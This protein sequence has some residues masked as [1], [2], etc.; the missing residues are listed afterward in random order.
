MNVRFGS[1][2][3][4]K[5]RFIYHSKTQPHMIESFNNFQAFLFCEAKGILKR[6]LP[7]KQFAF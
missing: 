3:A 7:A 1:N 4:K 6:L 2:I 5:S